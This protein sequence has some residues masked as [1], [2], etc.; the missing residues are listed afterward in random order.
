MYKLTV[1]YDYDGTTELIGR[2]CDEQSARYH[3]QSAIDWFVPMGGR[4]NLI[5]ET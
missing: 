3:E 2:Y 1:T 5:K 4:V